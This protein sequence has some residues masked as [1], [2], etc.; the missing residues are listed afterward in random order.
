MQS[1]VPH[2]RAQEARLALPTG[3]ATLA[4]VVRQA[5]GGLLLD[6]CLLQALDH[7]HQGC[8]VL[9]EGASYAGNVTQALQLQGAYIHGHVSPA[10]LTFSV[11]MISFFYSSIK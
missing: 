5:G 3:A 8:R 11:T 1:P 10:P 2:A 7:G 6:A 4:L 9:R